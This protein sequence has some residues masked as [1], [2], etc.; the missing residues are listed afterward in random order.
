MYFDM[1]AKEWLHVKLAISPVNSE[2]TF[3][4]LNEEIQ[5][6][7]FD[8][9]KEDAPNQWDKELNKV[10][11]EAGK[12]NFYTALYHAFLGPTEYMDVD[13][14]YRGLDINIH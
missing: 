10:M 3:N 14:K 11:V 9:L 8:K 4:Y 12:M 6:W 7:D 13:G 2:G 5:H 1:E